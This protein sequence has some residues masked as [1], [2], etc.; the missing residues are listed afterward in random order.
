[1]QG[2]RQKDAYIATQGPLPHTVED[3]W[4]MVWNVQ[5]ASVVML[6]ELVE[7]GQAK[8]ALYW[9]KEGTEAYGDLR[10]EKSDEVDK[11]DYTEREFTLSNALEGPGVGRQQVVKQVNILHM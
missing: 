11:E 3:F 7:K 5:A 1:M 2:Y 6:T 8:C 4:R 10:V 9:P